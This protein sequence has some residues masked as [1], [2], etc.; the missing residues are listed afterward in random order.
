MKKTNHIFTSTYCIIFFKVNIDYI[1]SLVKWKLHLFCHIIL[2]DKYKFKSMS[3]IVN[4]VFLSFG[5]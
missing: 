2:K 1:Q 5:G 4:Y 3:M